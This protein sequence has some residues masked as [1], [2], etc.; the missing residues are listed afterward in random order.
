MSSQS[1]ADQFSTISTNAAVV[2]A[3]LHDP[4]VGEREGGVGVCLQMNQLAHK[5]LQELVEAGQFQHLADT[6]LHGAS[7]ILARSDCGQRSAVGET[8]EE[9]SHS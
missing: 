4:S 9:V 3:R 2:T 1:N 6:W 5:T 8:D 7:T